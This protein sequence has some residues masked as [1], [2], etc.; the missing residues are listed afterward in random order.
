MPKVVV[1]GE[2]VYRC[3]VCSRNIRVPVNR[4]GLDVIQRCIITHNCRGKLHRVSL[5]KD[6]NETPAFPQEVQGVE[7]W[8]QRRVLY[9]HEQPVRSSV[10]TIKHNLSNQPRVYAYVNQTVDG[11]E[12][13]VKQEPLSTSTVSPNVTLVTFD[14][15]VSGLAQC[16]A[17]ASQNSTNSSA[18]DVSVESSEAFQVTTDTGELT[19]ATLT[20][21]PLVGLG[22][23]YRTSGTSIDVTIDYAGIDSTPAVNSP[24]SNAQRVVV[25]GKVYHTRSFNLTTTPL[26]PVY[27]ASGA[28][29]DGST[30]FVSTLNGVSPS[31]GQCLILLSQAPHATADRVH[32]RYIDIASVNTSTPEL[33]YMDGKGFAYP[34]VIKTAYPLVMSV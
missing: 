26:A 9:T 2:N 11:K 27:F 16:V 10:W 29:P 22:L 25:N 13:L 17:T 15:A 6:I 31:P 34:T 24:W 19:I 30:F 23:T 8:F 4:Q 12:T 18:T 28:V 14:S 21:A 1:R 33:Y 5:S 3:T 7:D 20:D 32:D